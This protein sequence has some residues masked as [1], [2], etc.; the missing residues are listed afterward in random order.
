MELPALGGTSTPGAVHRLDIVAADRPH[1]Q[2]VDEPDHHARSTAGVSKRPPDRPWWLLPSGR[3]NPLWWVGISGALL[4]IDYFTGL[5]SIGPAL[6]VIPVMLA[7]WYS[8]LWAALLVAV[9]SPLAHTATLLVRG[10][11][12]QP[13]AQFVI[14]TA[15][16][17]MVIAVMALWF[18]RL[19][20]HEQ[21]LERRVKTLEGLLSICSFCKNICNEH[22][23]WERLEKVISERSEARFS[24]GFCPACIKE[25]FP[26]YPE[27]S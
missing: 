17:G 4:A 15:T 25:H 3:L 22:G 20:E 14:M 13:L 12:G 19:S 9:A 11:L 18:A 1:A 24:H 27:D 16:R 5:Y 23:E 21:E 7:A 6:Y 26:D 10:S 2:G 8:G